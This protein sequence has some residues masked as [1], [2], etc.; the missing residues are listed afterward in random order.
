MTG[1]NPLGSLFSFMDNIPSASNNNPMGMLGGIVNMMG[2]AASQSDDPRMQQIG[3]YMGDA[4][5]W[6][7]GIGTMMG[8]HDGSP[9][10]EGSTGIPGLRDNPYGVMSKAYGMD[11]PQPA[12]QQPDM[13]SYLPQQ[14]LS[15]MSGLM[16]GGSMSQSMRGQNPYYGSGPVDNRHAPTLPQSAYDGVVDRGPMPTA[17]QPTQRVAPPVASAPTAPSH[18][19][20]YGL[21]EAIRNKLGGLFGGT[22]PDPMAGLY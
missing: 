6:L 17:P 11:K 22:R 12:D 2:G 19:F 18:G 8:P 20:G 10:M 3:K 16:G 9:P 1:F 4:Q 5:G 14:V 21:G 7:N 13:G 15:T